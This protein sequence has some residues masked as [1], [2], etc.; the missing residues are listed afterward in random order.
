MEDKHISLNDVAK[1]LGV[2]LGTV[3]YYLR[4]LK[5]QST[6]FPLDKRAYLTRTQF[7]MIKGLKDQAGARA[8][9]GDS[10]A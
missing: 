5:I 3:H 10:A 6:K 8:K 9:S 4:T 1:E 7:E 2:T